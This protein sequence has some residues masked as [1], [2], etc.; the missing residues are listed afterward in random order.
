[1]ILDVFTYLFDFDG[2]KLDKGLNDGTDKVKKLGGH[3]QAAEEMAGHLGGSFM[4]TLKSGAAALAGIVA[5]GSLVAG[6]RATIDAADALGEVSAALD[7]NVDELDAWGHAVK[8]SGGSAEGF[9]GS[10]RTL[11]ASMAQM[12]T[13]GKS[14]VAPFFKEL[15]VNM[16]DAAGKMRPVMD[17]LPELAESFGQMDKAQAMGMGQR[18]GLDQGTIMLLQKG[19]VAVEDLVKRQKE[20]GVISLEAAEAAG[21]FND[22][23]DDTAHMGRSGFAELGTVVLPVLSSVLRAIQATGAYLSE[24][25]SFVK[26]F[27][28][29]VAAI[30]SYLYVPAMIKAAMATNFTFLPILAM[31]L[32]IAGLAAAFALAY[33]DIVTFMEGG[34]SMIGRVAEKWPI[35]G[36]I[37]RTWVHY[38]GLLRDI[39]VAV[40]GLL[41]DLIM[42]PA[43]AWDN[44]TASMRGAFDTFAGSSPQMMALVGRIGEAFTDMGRDVMAV[45]NMITAA[46]KATIDLISGGIDAL[47]GGIAK[48]SGWLGMGDAQAAEV[49]LTA[50]GTL[51]PE[52]AAAMAKGQ[53]ELAI[54]SASPLA[55]QTSN[56]VSTANRTTS[57]TTTVQVAKIEVNTA[58]T[59]SQGIAQGIGGALGDQLKQVNDHYD[60]GMAY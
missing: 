6:F 59:D 12:D 11:T 25:G 2:A 33:D 57:K 48:V 29:G 36:D 19:R 41:A 4:E 38:L 39:A 51:P 14:R 32:A 24:H 56:S 30:V 60:D 21:D 54:A 53:Q 20:L 52:T 55:A 50:P 22:A 18:L 16:L 35:V 10:L 43:N 9:Q 27:F 3:M 58:A 44:F 13:V 7:I 26:A 46:I 34:D 31:G 42:D 17:L 1:M 45:W 15:G 49:A 47:A 28:T 5:V 40:F 23:L 37:V 8:M